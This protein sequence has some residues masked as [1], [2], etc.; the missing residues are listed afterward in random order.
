MNIILDRHILRDN[1]RKEQTPD[2]PCAER[3][4]LAWLG[5]RIYSSAASREY[6]WPRTQRAGY[7]VR[8]T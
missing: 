2:K 8:S 4:S 5:S 7:K 3:H 6:A 1:A